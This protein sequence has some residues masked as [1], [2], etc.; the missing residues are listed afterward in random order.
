MAWDR[1]PAL[2][3]LG[4]GDILDELFAV[5]R[6]GF[7]TLLGIAAFIHVPL[8]LLSLPL[9][10]ASAGYWREH[11]N[12]LWWQFGAQPVPWNAMEGW[13]AI[14]SVLIFLVSFVA[15]SLELAAVVYATSALCLG[16]PVTIGEAYRRGL[17]RFWAIVRASL[18]LVGLA[19][20]LMVAWMVPAFVSPA[21]I[22]LTSPLAIGAAVYLGVRWSLA[23]PALV[24]EG[25]G[26]IAALG[27]SQA[28][29]RGAWWRTLL[30]LILLGILLLVLWGIAYALVSALVSGVQSVL[31]PGVRG[32]TDWAAA[33]ES[34]LNS[35]VGLV[36]GPLL[37]IGLTLMYYDRRVRAEAYDL[38]VL[39]Q[40]LLHQQ[41]PEP[42][43]A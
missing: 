33:V 27:R 32:Q 1:A 30:T 15:G 12:L 6:R 3:P 42:G 29:V 43:T 20:A 37:Y 17:S 35:A 18:L 10:T 13:Q 28:L 31:A 23:I 9:A 22:C 41:R 36:F 21:L 7:K 19:V 2:R 8:A 39:A 16:R 25:L 11:P 38:S 24:V 14:V 40:D 26:A 4:I 34:L 5:Y